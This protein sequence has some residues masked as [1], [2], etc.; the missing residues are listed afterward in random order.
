MTNAITGISIHVWPKNS[1]NYFQLF[2]RT[3]ENCAVFSKTASIAFLVDSQDLK[4]KPSISIGGL[5]H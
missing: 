3:C 1:K 4:I 5:D 2:L